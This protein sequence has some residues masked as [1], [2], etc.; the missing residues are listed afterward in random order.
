MQKKLPTYNPHRIND[1]KRS[2]TDDLKDSESSLLLWSN[3]EGVD[4]KK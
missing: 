1:V 4:I 2:G 3:D